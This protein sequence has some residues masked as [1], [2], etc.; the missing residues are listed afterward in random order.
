S[1]DEVEVGAVIGADRGQGIAGDV[2]DVDADRADRSYLAL[3]AGRRALL[4][5]TGAKIGGGRLAVGEQIELRLAGE[6]GAER[7]A[8]G[9]ALLA[10][11]G[12]I[13]LRAAAERDR[14]PLA[15]MP[16]QPY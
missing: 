16:A 10:A 6:V 5:Q 14:G 2:A 9:K 15:R 12:L 4:P 3:I 8:V 11:A 13:E 1:I 7:C